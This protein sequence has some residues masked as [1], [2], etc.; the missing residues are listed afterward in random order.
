MILPPTAARDNIGKLC[1]MESQNEV[2]QL[3]RAW[4]AGDQDAF[5]KLTGLVYKELHRLARSYMIR[6]R[7]D[8]TLQATALINEAY[9]R[10]MDA[11]N[12]HWKDRA[13]FFAVSAKLMRRIL[14]DF[15]RSRR[16]QKRGADVRPVSL[17]ES[18]IVSPQKSPDILAVDEALKKLAAVDPRKSS[19]VELRFFGGLTVEETAEVLQ[20]APSTI[21]HDYDLAKLWLLRE[22]ERPD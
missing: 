9:I 5:E 14:V 22:I 19:I 6:E 11:K 13:H 12:V 1:A 2:T 18:A 20:L 16:S 21:Y 17:D 10:L 15:A 3:L 8:H 4:G 7:A